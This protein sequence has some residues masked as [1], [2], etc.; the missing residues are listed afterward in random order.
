MTEQNTLSNS[1][2]QQK[3]EE[4]NSQAQF[5]LACCLLKGNDCD[6]DRDAAFP[7]FNK[8][9]KLGNPDM[10]IDEA[11]QWL[12]KAAELGNPEAQLALGLCFMNGTL[13]Q[14]SN[15]TELHLSMSGK[16]ITEFYNIINFYNIISNEFIYKYKYSLGSHFAINYLRLV[17]KLYKE[18]NFDENLAFSWLEKSAKQ[19]CGEAQYWLARCYQTGT[20]IQQNRELAFLWFKNNAEQGYVDAFYRLALCYVNGEGVEKNNELAFTWLTKWVDLQ[21]EKDYDECYVNSFLLLG[22]LY[23]DGKGVQQN[24]QLALESYLK[25]Y[26]ICCDNI[27]T[28]EDGKSIYNNVRYG[29]KPNQEQINRDKSPWLKLLGEVSSRVHEVCK[30]FTISGISDKDAYVWHDKLAKCG[31][32]ESQLWLAKYYLS[33]GILEQSD[34]LITHSSRYNK[35]ANLA[36]NATEKGCAEAGLIVGFLAFFGLCSSYEYHKDESEEFFKKAM[37]QSEQ[38]IAEYFLVKCCQYSNNNEDKR[39]MDQYRNLADL[40]KVWSYY[41]ID[42]L[43]QMDESLREKL[44]ILLKDSEL[45]AVNRELEAK[46]RQLLQAQKELEEMM[47]MFAH[48]FR[49]PLDAI[50]S[51]TTHENQVKLYTEAAQ[52]MRGLLDIFSIISTDHEILKDKIKLDKQGNGRLS[53]VF[54]KTLDMIML[55]L[56]SASG[57]EKIQQHYMAYAKSHALCGSDLSYKSWI[58]DCIELEQQLQSEWELGFAHLLGESDKLE[59]RLTWLEQRFFK[60]ELSGFEEANIQFRANGVTESFLMILLNEILVNA[61]KYYSSATR[62]PVVLE[63]TERDGHQVLVCRNPSVRSE[64]TIIKGSHKGHAFL[65]TLAR[66]TGSQFVKP[67]PQ[68]EFVLEFGIP[69]ELLIAL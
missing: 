38:G 4:G 8:K 32:A 28:I 48:K 31:H 18:R 7:W 17:Y 30:S 69:N 50:I 15:L 21:Q 40:E 52:T 68:D 61:F 49:S 12:N 10:N 2:L 47:S 24:I 26:K 9:A 53:T 55:H 16:L 35:A 34:E 22:N 36:C 6:S 39:L 33:G 59:P 44:Q 29:Y 64:R 57:A 58:E 51:N 42:K 37:G 3:A 14:E 63:W 19:G 25:V 67:Q 56:L 43:L 27:V 62:K 20:G 23:A 5:Y 45:I 13:S 46:N 1:E 65:S 66:K 41:G 60:L 11:L 54:I